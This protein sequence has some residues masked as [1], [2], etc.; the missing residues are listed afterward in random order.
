MKN[1]LFD[2]FLYY[3]HKH[4]YFDIEFE[5]FKIWEIL[6]TYVYIDIEQIYN[7]LQPLFPQTSKKRLKKISLNT[8]IK[9]FKIF[10][11]K[12]QDYIFLNNPRRVKQKDGKYYCVY[13]DLLIDLLKKDYKCIT[14]EDP[15]W[16]L[17]PS[18]NVSHF[19]PVKTDSIC[20]L[21]FIEHIFKI[22]K[23][24][25]KKIFTKNYRELHSIIQK[26]EKDVEKEFECDLSNIFRIGED[27][28]IY[29]LL[30]YK[31]YKKIIKRINPK[32]VF[33]F[34]DV[35]PSKIVV[36]KIAKELK[37]PIIEIQH[38][39]VTENN[40]I[41]LKYY[42][43]NRKY[44]CLPDYVLSYGK[45]LLNTKHMPINKSNIY[46]IGSLFLETK[47]KEYENEQTSKKN[48]LFVSQSNLGKYIS[49]CA[50]KLSDLLKNNNEYHIIY[51]MHPYEIGT[52]YEC[53]KKKNITII[54]N[55]DK[56]LY[57]F[58]SISIAQVGVYSTGLYEGLAFGL[59]TFIL[60]NC[61]GSKEIKSILKKNSNI[62]YIDEVHEILKKI[63]NKQISKTF[64]SDYWEYVDYDKISNIILSISNK[65]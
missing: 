47:K 23:Y 31:I 19:E 14:F 50:S 45:R 49:E 56:D 64:N 65:K 16:A 13:T 20:Y 10:F 57:Y 17:S 44:D 18:T 29:I 59:D 55:R 2:K 11:T 39:I 43:L 40:P 38:G 61:Y 7:K 46:C 5:G 6:R 3:E 53:L 9:S 4:K 60:N 21:D 12:K 33:E 26:I 30:T 36:N 22:K 63:K 1:N 54:N 42:D 8:I 27:K 15:Y 34:Y 62:H 51:K 37:I 48:I 35:F 24:F 28:I 58:Q 25:F 52:E 41:F 32:A